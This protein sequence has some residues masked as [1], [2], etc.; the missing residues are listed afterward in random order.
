A[1]SAAVSG[2]SMAAVGEW[3]PGG[4]GGSFE[5][6]GTLVVTGASTSPWEVKV[7]N[8]VSGLTGELKAGETEA[9]IGVLSKHAS[10]L[11]I[12]TIAEQ[13]FN[14]ANGITPQ[15]D[16]GKAVDLDSFDAGLTKLTLNVY[17]DASQKIGVMKADFFAG[18]I[19][20]M[21]DRGYKGAYSLMASEAGQAF[22]GGVAK[23]K[24]GS[25]GY[26]SLVN[27]MMEID[28]AAVEHFDLQNAPVSEIVD[29]GSFKTPFA[30]YSGAYTSAIPYGEA[31]I[32]ITLDK[33]MGNENVDWHASLPITV[34]YA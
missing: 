32:K 29:T 24:G 17:N 16:Y 9:T 15:I 27:K 28:Q 22:Y 8:A 23:S 25:L 21:N 20:S 3:T 26:N 33:P 18:A 10:V 11:S 14:G 6:G 34:T 13:A 4:E 2:T 7:A 19:Y 31:S 5:M 1:A 12:R 30:T